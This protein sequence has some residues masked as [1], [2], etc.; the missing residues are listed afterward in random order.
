M[1]MGGVPAND[2]QRAACASLG[3]VFAE[4]VTLDDIF[5]RIARAAPA[6]ERTAAAAGAR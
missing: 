3:Q 4:V 6:A 1:E 2:L 5:G